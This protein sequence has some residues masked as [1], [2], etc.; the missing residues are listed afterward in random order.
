[1]HLD[2]LDR[3]RQ[4]AALYA[5]VRAE[6][7]V[8][9]A[10]AGWAAVRDRLHLEHAPSAAGLQVPAY[11]PDWR[12]EVRV[13]AAPPLRLDLPT[14]TGDVLPVERVGRLRTPWGGLDAWW[15]RSYGG[16]LWVPVR[17]PRGPVHGRTLYDTACGVDLGSTPDGHLVVDL[18]FLVQPA[19]AHDPRWT[20]PLPPDSAVLEVEIPVGE[21]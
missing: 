1:M 5:A 14:T 20:C 13:E 19:C 2:L 10:H 21:T 12:V 15:L 17:T 8:P 16:G 3:Q 9:T 7:H 18:N 4:T 11:D 6:R